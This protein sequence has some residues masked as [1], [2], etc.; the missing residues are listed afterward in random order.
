[1][2]TDDTVEKDRSGDG[3]DEIAGVGEMEGDGDT[4]RSIGGDTLGSEST[5]SMTEYSSTGNENAPRT[6]GDS[7]TRTAIL[8]EPSSTVEFRVNIRQ[9]WMP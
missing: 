2:D 8:R 4:D 6:S 1:L 9:G 7:G 3:H 5:S